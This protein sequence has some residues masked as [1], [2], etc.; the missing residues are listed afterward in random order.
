MPG[1]YRPISLT[2]I[3]GKLMET[4]IWEKIVNHLQYLHLISDL[5]YG[6]QRNRLCLIDL[7]DLSHNIINMSDKS[8]A[9][10]IY[11][12][13]HKAC[14]EVH[15]QWLQAKVELHG[16]NGVELGWLENW[17]TGYNLKWLTIKPQNG[18]TQ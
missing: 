18:Y 11:L 1:Y 9:T 17:L 14:D 6:L 5:H 10:D 13:F 4:T 2:S 12:D 15:R 7:L 3:L 8:K 16:I